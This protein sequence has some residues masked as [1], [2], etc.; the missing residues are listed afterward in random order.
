MIR[1]DSRSTATLCRLG[2]RFLV[3]LALAALWPGPNVAEVTAMLCF[4]LASGCLI[5]AL[6]RREPFR[7]TGLNHWYEAAALAMIGSMLLIR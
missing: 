4:G 2:F 6:A 7:G 1:L 3:S 5:T